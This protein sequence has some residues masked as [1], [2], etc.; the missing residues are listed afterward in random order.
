MTRL[1]RMSALVLVLMLLGAAC[2]DSG[3]EGGGDGD[4]SDATQV[5]STTA[6]GGDGGDTDETVI[7]LGTLA[8]NIPGIDDECVAVANVFGYL[9]QASFALSGQADFDTSEAQQQFEAA[10][11]QLP[12][13]L[14]DDLEVLA[15]GL[16]AFYE[17]IQDSGLD[18]TDP[19]AVPDASQ[20]AALEE[21]L[22][23]IDTEEFDAATEVLGNYADEQCAGLTE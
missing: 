13:D 19:G 12:G 22:A 11:A 4:G 2:G 15:D 17:A 18:L 14:Q 21:A 5:T 1:F 10:A 7:T 8:E 6:G 3:D 9:A 16:F 23:T 20:L